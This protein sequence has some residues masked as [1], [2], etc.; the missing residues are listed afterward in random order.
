[1]TYLLDVNV[2]IALMDPGHVQHDVAHEWLA[3][4]Q[5]HGGQ[6]ATLDRRLVVAAVHGGA[7]TLCL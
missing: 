1:M 5:A 7:D 2:L 6:L 3:L 4:A